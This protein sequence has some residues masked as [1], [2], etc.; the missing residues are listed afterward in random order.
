MQWVFLRWFERSR[1]RTDVKLER[2]EIQVAELGVGVCVGHIDIL[3]VEVEEMKVAT[4]AES[5]SQVAEVLCQELGVESLLHDRVVFDEEGLV[6]VE[7]VL[8]DVVGALVDKAE[9]HG[10]RRTYG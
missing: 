6:G 3:V 8:G 7:H 4:V 2:F 10:V 5:E 9:S 1:W